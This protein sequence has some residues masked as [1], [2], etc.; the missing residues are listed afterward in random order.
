[1]RGEALLFLQNAAFLVKLFGRNLFQ[2]DK[3]NTLIHACSHFPSLSHSSG[4]SVTALHL[5]VEAQTE[6]LLK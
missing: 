6:T 3:L 1:M 5:S 4:C 2:L